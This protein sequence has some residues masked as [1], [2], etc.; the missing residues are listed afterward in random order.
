MEDIK[1]KNFIILLLLT[2]LYT[3]CNN[4]NKEKQSEVVLIVKGSKNIVI[5][6][7]VTCPLH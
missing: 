2:I 3:A 1:M 5:N 7:M 4:I 6:N